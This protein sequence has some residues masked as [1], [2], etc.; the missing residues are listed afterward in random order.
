MIE[1]SRIVLDGFKLR[2][3]AAL[4]RYPDRYQDP[5]GVVMWDRVNRLIA[6]QR[7]RAAA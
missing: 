1:A 3:D 2:A 5:R 4:V 6:A 7:E